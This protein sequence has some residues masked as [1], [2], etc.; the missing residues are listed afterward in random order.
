MH[1]DT[2]RGP[3]DAG[4]Y[5][6][7]FRRGGR[8]MKGKF[9][10]ELA[11]MLFFFIGAGL[12]VLFMGQL[13]APPKVLMGRMLTAISPSLFPTLILTMLSALSAV[14]VW[15]TLKKPA[16]E[17]TEPT[18]HRDEIIRGVLL[19][20][21]MTLYAL[22]MVPFGF[23]ISSFISLVLISWLSGNRSIIQIVALAII[24]P[25]ALY[26]V[27]TRVLAVSLPELNAIELFYAQQLGL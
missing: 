24:G 10:T 9:T 1:R 17:K 21:F 3:W 18:L 22:M 25:V 4:L 20:A 27:A 2:R 16:E 7:M 11:V 12:A 26:L 8:D 15:F 6:E 5:Y 14:M 13:V 19:F 23:L